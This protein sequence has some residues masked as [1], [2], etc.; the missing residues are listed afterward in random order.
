[1]GGAAMGAERGE[2]G[3][4]E[5]EPLDATDGTSGSSGEATPTTLARVVVER[6][7]SVDG[8]ESAQAMAHFVEWDPAAAHGL[9]LV[10]LGSDL[11]KAIPA[12]GFCRTEF[13]IPAAVGMTELELLDAGSVEIRLSEARSTVTL[14]PHAFPS[15]S[16][17][18]AGLVYTTRDRS[19]DALPSGTRYEIVVDGARAVPRLMF[20][21]DAPV[22]LSQ[23]T[24]GGVPLENVV[25]V[26]ASAPLD[27]TWAVGEERD[28]VVV[29]FTRPDDGQ[30]E[31]SCTF[32][33]DAGAAT[34]SPQLLEAARGATRLSIHRVRH[35]VA[36][37]PN[38]PTRGV[39]AE[40]AQVQEVQSELRFDFELNRLL[41]I[42]DRVEVV[43]AEVPAADELVGLEDTAAAH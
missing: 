14:A 10:G 22:A 17:L 36:A 32:A 38:G 43:A 6:S 31:L 11:P 19:A 7:E 28:V 5:A 2:F 34:V 33:D 4:G 27:I 12:G 37:T 24:L 20:A 30:L 8:T 29:E 15:V 21:G 18:A 16:S 42:G 40:G 26:D 25:G 41:A 1:M 39:A 35:I 9:E 23:V 13:P 3:G